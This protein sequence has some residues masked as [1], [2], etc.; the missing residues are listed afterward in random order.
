V[1]GVEA[2]A[3]LHASAAYRTHL[4]IVHAGRALAKALARAE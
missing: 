3:D 2:N 1:Q 4:A